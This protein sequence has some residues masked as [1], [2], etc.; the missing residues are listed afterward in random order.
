VMLRDAKHKTHL[1]ERFAL[2]GSVR[3]QPP[4]DERMKLNE[5]PPA[6]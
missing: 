1:L 3:L 2:V 4:F 6:V 5:S